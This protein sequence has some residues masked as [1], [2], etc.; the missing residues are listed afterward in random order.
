MKLVWLAGKK[1]KTSGRFSGPVT[2]AADVHNLLPPG[3]HL[4]HKSVGEGC[5]GKQRTI[6]VN[7]DVASAQHKGIPQCAVAGEHVAGVVGKSHVFQFESMVLCGVV[8]VLYRPDLQDD[9]NCKATLHF[10]ATI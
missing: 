9:P 4:P 7:S 5:G 3:V 8:K 6:P 2:G 10:L 1:A